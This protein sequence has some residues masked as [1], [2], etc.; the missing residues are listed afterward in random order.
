MLDI[1]AAWEEKVD[2][3]QNFAQALRY[4]DYAVTIGLMKANDRLKTTLDAETNS[5]YG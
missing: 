5:R 1:E 3:C 2:N 4:G